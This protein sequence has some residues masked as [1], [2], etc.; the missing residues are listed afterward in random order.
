MNT[1]PGLGRN[2]IAVCAGPLPANPQRPEKLS[3]DPSRS[4]D[5]PRSRRGVYESAARRS[6]RAGGSQ[7]READR[8][9]HREPHGDIPVPLFTPDEGAWPR[10]TRL[11]DQLR[12]PSRRLSDS[13]SSRRRITLA[14]IRVRLA[15]SRSAR[16]RS[17][18]ARSRGVR[19]HLLVV[20]SKN[21]GS[22]P[23]R[24]RCSPS[25]VAGVLQA[26]RLGSEAFQRPAIGA[27][28]MWIP[29]NRLET[30]AQPIDHRNC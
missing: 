18:S 10:L 26:L 16:A 24:S 28:R 13:F 21:L 3:R 22:T 5:A 19:S 20:G 7:G 12:L 15:F 27:L 23:E 14:S 8:A 4:Q 6:S 2:T 25:T 29:G 1:V 9:V 30:C 17:A 11:I